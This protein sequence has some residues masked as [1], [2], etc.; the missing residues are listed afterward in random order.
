MSVYRNIERN[1]NSFVPSP[2]ELV[3]LATEKVKEAAGVKAASIDLV[4]V[5]NHI[6]IAEVKFLIK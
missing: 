6:R 4:Q 2:V 1:P 3:H 5:H